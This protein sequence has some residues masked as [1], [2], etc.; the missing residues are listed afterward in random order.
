M[1]LLWLLA[2]FMDSSSL[3]LPLSQRLSPGRSVAFCAPPPSFSLER[4]LHALFSILLSLCKPC[5]P[6]GRFQVKWEAE[7]FQWNDRH[8]C[9]RI[10]HL[11]R[12]EEKVARWGSERK[13]IPLS[14]MESETQPISYHRSRICN[15]LE[16]PSRSLS[17]PPF[18]RT[19]QHGHQHG[20]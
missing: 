9:R 7:L 4:K 2:A 17:W 11:G 18:L 10:S 1:L 15:G 6:A 12:W 14:L 20:P 8:S 5:Q 3:L 19:H 16:V 13:G